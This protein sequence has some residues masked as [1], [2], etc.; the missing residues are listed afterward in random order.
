MG[1]ENL[2]T[3]RVIR[4]PFESRTLTVRAEVFQ[5]VVPAEPN[6]IVVPPRASGQ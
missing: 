5:I 2:N 3:D 4:V 1:K 6:R